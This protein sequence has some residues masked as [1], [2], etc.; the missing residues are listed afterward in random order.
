MKVIVRADSAATENKPEITIMAKSSSI[1]L[2]KFL[3][4]RMKVTK[5]EP[6]YDINHLLN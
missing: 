5:K 6:I 2:L 3:M 1:D 4:S